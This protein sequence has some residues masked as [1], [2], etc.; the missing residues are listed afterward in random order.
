MD[1]LLSNAIKY[2]PADGHVKVSAWQQEDGIFISVADSGEGIPPEL[3]G[4]VTEKFYRMDKSRG[5]EGVGLGLS[6]VK[7]IVKLHEGEL[8]FSSNNPGLVAMI[9]LK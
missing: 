1:N 4:K 9:V 8:F 7:A 6:L 5:S 3:Y 2:T